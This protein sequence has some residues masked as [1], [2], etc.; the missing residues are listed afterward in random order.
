[1]RLE[2]RDRMFELC[3]LIQRETDLKKLTL[4][5]ADWNELVHRKILELS[6]PKK[7]K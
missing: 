7:T 6:R 4:W 3:R 1:M 5:I 2:D